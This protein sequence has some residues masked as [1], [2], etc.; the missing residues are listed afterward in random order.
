MMQS[1]IKL[2]SKES[3]AGI[4]V[5]KSVGQT[6]YGSGESVDSGDNCFDFLRRFDEVNLVVWVDGSRDYLVAKEAMDRNV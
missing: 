5:V 4:L 1:R 2:I 6:W 3:C